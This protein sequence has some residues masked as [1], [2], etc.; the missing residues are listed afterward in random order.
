MPRRRLDR[1]GAPGCSRRHGVH[2]GAG[3]ERDRATRR[4]RRKTRRCRRAGHGPRPTWP[5]R[6]CGRRCRSGPATWWSRP[7]APAVAEALFAAVEPRLTTFRTVRA[8]GR[9]L[10]PEAIVRTLW[11]EGE[12]PFPARLAMRTLLDE[13]RDA[14]GS[15]SSWRSPTRS[16]PTRPARARPADARGRAR[17]GRDRPHR[18]AGRPG[19]DRAA[20][21]AR[22][23]RRGAAHRRERA[24]AGRWRPRSGRRVVLAAREAAPDRHRRGVVVAASRARRWIGGHCPWFS[25][26]PPSPP[27][28][29]RRRRS[30]RHPRARTAGARHLPCRPPPHTCPMPCRRG[31]R[32]S[33]TRRPMRRRR[34]HRG[35]QG[36]RANG[37][38]APEP[39]QSRRRR[40]RRPHPSRRRLRPSRRRR[41]RS[42][43]HRHGQARRS[44]SGPSSESES[45]EAL[46]AKLAAAVSARSTCR[47]AA[48]G[49][50]MFHRVRVSGF[51][52]AHDVTVAEGW[53]RA[54]G[55]PAT[56]VRE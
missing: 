55:Y 28:V 14:S 52:S 22:G 17:R 13:A 15:R 36:A 1:A 54:A 30:R 40:H 25:L 21:P 23:A 46:R 43:P 49:T 45:A 20:A 50:T 56:R 9:T 10:D 47:R 6:S 34:P 48:R 3:R 53:L 35:R 41:S 8:S 42:T 16:S 29:P 27:P 39:S 32:W 26:K 5:S 19:P 37:A 44:R 51:R 7:R 2:K 31:P 24:G 12:P 18:A 38:R 4:R 33:T 11:R